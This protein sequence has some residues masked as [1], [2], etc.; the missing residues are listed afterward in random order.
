MRDAFGSLKPALWLCATP[1][2]YGAFTD[3]PRVAQAV[4]KAPGA[5]TTV[6][7]RIIRPA[8]RPAGFLF[9]CGR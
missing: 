4:T 8:G 6:P 1:S 2:L 9:L 3:Q 5:N 7:T